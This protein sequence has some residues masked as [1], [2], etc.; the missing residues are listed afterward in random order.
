[1]TAAHP[2]AQPTDGCL[3]PGLPHWTAGEAPGRPRLTRHRGLT[4]SDTD[5]MSGWDRRAVETPYCTEELT[6]SRGHGKK[7]NTAKGGES[8]AGAGP[9]SWP[10]PGGQG[11]SFLGRMTPRSKQAH[12]VWEG[13]RVRMRKS[14][15]GPPGGSGGR[16]PLKGQG[17][18]AGTW[19][20]ERPPLHGPR[21]TGRPVAEP[22]SLPQP[23]Q[24]PPA[25]VPLRQD[26]G[27]AGSLDPSP[28]LPAAAMAPSPP[29]HAGPARP[30][31][32][33]V[34]T[35]TLAPCTGACGGPS[36]GERTHLP[37]HGLQPCR[38]PPA[39][40]GPLSPCLLFL[41]SR[42]SRESLL[43]FR[44]RPR[45]RFPCLRSPFL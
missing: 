39:V 6:V 7:A 1:M 34:T 36:S 35:C 31:H 33:A 25:S 14:C 4:R 15:G 10:R 37:Y 21:W 13:L 29:H 44:G 27:W 26:E 5:Q 18:G 32:R 41:P 19:C 2:G 45:F 24:H 38:A 11:D 22:L 23:A 40:Q 30:C 8:S 12:C 43:S 17:Q 3:P 28:T 20:V 42:H 9:Q 16:S